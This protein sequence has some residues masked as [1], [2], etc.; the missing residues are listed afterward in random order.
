LR[1][2]RLTRGARSLLM[3]II[4]LACK[5]A[6]A[7]GASAASSNAGCVCVAC[8]VVHV[9]SS[10]AAGCLPSSACPFPPVCLATNISSR[11]VHFLCVTPDEC[12]SCSAAGVSRKKLSVPMLEL[13]LFSCLLTTPVYLLHMNMIMCSK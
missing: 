1:L 7:K 3:L 9:I 13:F 2:R 6:A 10:F 12:T 4:F 11:R 8:L 5:G